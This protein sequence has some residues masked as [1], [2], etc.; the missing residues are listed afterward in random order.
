[1]KLLVITNNPERASF[2]QRIGVYLDTLRSKGID[3]KVGKLPNGALARLKL[4]RTASEFDGVFLHKK[5]LNIFDAFWL[6]RYSKKII[7]NFDDAIMYS[8]KTPERYSH[9]HFTSFRRSVKLADMIIVGSS[10]LA[11]HARPYNSNV[12]VLPIGLNVR[13]YNVEQSVSKDDKIRLVWIGSKNTLRY[14][15]EIK[16]A[17]EEIG[18]HFDNVVLRIICD[19]FFELENMPVEKYLWSKET[20]AIDLAGG[21][22]GLAPLPSNRFT[23][24]K[25]SFKVLEYAAS[26]LP[27]VA[28]PVGTNS[29]YVRDNST[30]FLATDMKM[31]VDRIMQLIE[32]KPLREKMGRQGRDFAENFDVSVI[33]KKLD[34][35]IR[36]CLKDDT[37]TAK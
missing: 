6:R 29:D 3:A 27:V 4:F 22:I 5:G 10:Y 16:P 12:E 30:G 26:G 28:S 7:F 20:R 19:D 36:Q 18:S 35:L 14:L 25:C 13:N 32:N 9:S 23:K 33:G 34:V 24:G 1:M 17:L 8:D 2:R 15:A 21:D 31:W 37:M 11:E